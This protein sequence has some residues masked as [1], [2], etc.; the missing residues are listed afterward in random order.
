MKKYILLINTCRFLRGLS[1]I[2]DACVN[3]VI[4]DRKA[5]NHSL[6]PPPTIRQYSLLSFALFCFVL[7]WLLKIVTSKAQ[8]AFVRNINIIQ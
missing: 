7:F 2:I 8:H 1:N 5:A 3:L 6:G 4:L